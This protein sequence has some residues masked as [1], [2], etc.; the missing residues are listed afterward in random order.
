[1]ALKGMVK[2][3]EARDNTELEAVL[4]E[5]DQLLSDNDTNIPIMKRRIALLRSMGRVSEAVSSLVQLLDFSPTDAEAWSE[6]ADLYFSQGMYPQA[7]YALEEVLVLVPNTWSIYARLGEMQYMAATASGATAG[8]GGGAYQQHMAEAIKRFTRSIEL[9]DDYLRGYYGLKL[10]TTRLLKDPATKSTKQTDEDEFT[11]P[12]VRTIER[13]NELATAKLA[14]I[15]RR[16]TAKEEGWRGY[17]EREVAA[18]Q[19]L[20]SQDVAASGIE[21]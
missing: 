11:L 6:L 20:L 15:V 16:N 4:K 13:L 17:D 1:M 7:I 18:A 2:E 10:V 14:E 12:D 3:A 5:Y 9:C 19:E 21:R 8:A